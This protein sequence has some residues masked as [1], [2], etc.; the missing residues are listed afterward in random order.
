MT[1]TRFVTTA[2]LAAAV[3]LPVS[4][5][6]L[7]AAQ[8]RYQEQL[9]FCNS[10]RLPDPERNACVRDAG[11]ALDRARGGP[12]RNVMSTTEDGR[13]TIIG[14]AGAPQPSGGTDEITSRD[15]RAT[16]VVP[17]NQAPPPSN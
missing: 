9:A 6:D 14:P 2:W 8:Q 1:R 15:G 17:A 13:A 5:Q 7:S 4:A 12:P 3:V 10:G 11:I 16:I